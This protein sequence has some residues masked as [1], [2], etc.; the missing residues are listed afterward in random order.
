MVFDFTQFWLEGRPGNEFFWI[1]HRISGLLTP[2]TPMG[3]HPQWFKSTVWNR[4]AIV[5]ILCLFISLN[6]MEVCTAKVCFKRN[7][8]NIFVNYQ[9]LNL[10]LFWSHSDPLR[11]ESTCS[12]RLVRQFHLYHPVCKDILSKVLYKHKRLLF[13]NFDRVFWWWKKLIS[14]AKA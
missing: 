11:L 14:F 3:M 13:C 4:Y 8:R 5:T 7:L 1:S 2:L 6:S 10:E 9:E 12:I